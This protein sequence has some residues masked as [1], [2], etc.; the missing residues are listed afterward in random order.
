M[1]QL[2]QYKA[3]KKDTQYYVN[4]YIG[5]VSLYI[6]YAVGIHLNVQRLESDPSQYNCHT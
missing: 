5:I 4:R 3:L 2:Q 1:L 6:I